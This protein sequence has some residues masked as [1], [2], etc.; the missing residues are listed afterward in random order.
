MN[1]SDAI[2]ALDIERVSRIVRVPESTLR[3]WETTGVFQPSYIDPNPRT[4]NRRIYSFRDVLS[5]RALAELRRN[6]NI[7][8]D[9]LRRAGR[10]LSEFYEA[11]WA[12][13]RFGVVVRRLVF[14]DPATQRWQSVQ[15][16]VVLPFD[17]A[18]LPREV[19]RSVDV[20]MQ[21]GV[22]QIGRI[23]QHRNVF[24]NRPVIAGTRIPVSMI[25]DYADAGYSA[26][27]IIN[28]YPQLDVADIEAALEH[29]AAR[30]SA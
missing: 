24:H 22:D 4:P 20:T 26:Q 1:D 6:L 25:R 23:E 5:L 7:K 2:L 19:Q 17:L 16:D 12:E 27:E 29:Q 30:L 28:E 15:G 18:D 9:D 8:L 21:R 10:Y 11:P 13:L 3:Y 14:R